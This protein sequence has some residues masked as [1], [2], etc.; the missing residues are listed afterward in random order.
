MAVLKHPSAD[1]ENGIGFAHQVII[2]TAGRSVAMFDGNTADPT[3][4]TEAVG[5]VRDT[6]ALR[7]GSSAVRLARDDLALALAQVA[8]GFALVHRRCTRIDRRDV[9]I[10]CRTICPQSQISPV[11]SAVMRFAAGPAFGLFV[12][13]AA[14]GQT[15]NLP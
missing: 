13:P 11:I 15:M 2:A 14:T 4:F 1:G 9:P 5:E 12:W 6:F 10:N 8:L 3:A 7:S